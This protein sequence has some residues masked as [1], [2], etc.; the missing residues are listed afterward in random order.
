VRSRKQIVNNGTGLT[1][2]F[3]ISLAR[4]LWDLGAQVRAHA[5]GAHLFKTCKPGHGMFRVLSGLVR[6]ITGRGAGNVPADREVDGWTAP[7]GLN[8]MADRVAQS[9]IPVHRL[10]SILP[11]ALG[12]TGRRKASCCRHPGI[13]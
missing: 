12:R 10:S 1:F 6:I 2:K 8:Q 4:F 9:R 7:H 13:A 5:D 11:R 3:Q